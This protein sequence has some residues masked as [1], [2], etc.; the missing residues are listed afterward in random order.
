M[1][2]AESARLL[3]SLL[4]RPLAEL[5]ISSAKILTSEIKD[6]ANVGGIF[7]EDTR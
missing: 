7:D 1:A 5:L 6:A 3:A 2:A 4:A